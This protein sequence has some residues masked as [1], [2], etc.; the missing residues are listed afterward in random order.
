MV[1]NSNHLRSPSVGILGTGRIGAGLGRL[2][3]QAGWDVVLG[4]RMPTGHVEGGPPRVTA[5]IAL[6]REVVIL[7][8]PHDAIATHSEVLRSGI[9]PDSL[10]VDCANALTVRDGS[11]RSALDQPHGQWLAGLLPQVRVARAFTHVQDELLVSRATRQPDTWAVGVAADDE[12]SL[13]QAQ[14]LIRAVRYVPVP[15]GALTDSAVLDPGGPL[16]PNMYLPADMRRL[17]QAWR[18][19]QVS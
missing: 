9:R 17:V 13:T 18:Q 10:V 16:F 5:P 2:L 19:Q 12:A 8:V 7:A 3:H 4:S 1:M 6:D 14:A 11:L 15:V